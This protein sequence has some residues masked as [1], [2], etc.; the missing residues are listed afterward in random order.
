MASYNLP[1]DQKVLAAIGTI[2][3]RHGQ[4]DNALKMAVKSL[5]SVSWAEAL[6]ATAM[7]T[8]RDLRDR[9]HKLA[10]QRFGEGP[11]LVKLDALLDRARK[12]SERRNEI[13]HSFWGTEKDTPVI[14][15]ANHNYKKAPTLKELK[16]LSDELYDIRAGVTDARLSGFLCDALKKSS[17]AKPK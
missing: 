5:A 2:A 14:R 4:L 10:K 3:I 17:P 1:D 15:D 11:A 7:S 12:A 9:I 13:L 8:G 16:S 6:D